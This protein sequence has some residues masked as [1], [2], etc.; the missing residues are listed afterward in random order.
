MSSESTLIASFYVIVQLVRPKC[1]RS[2]KFFC[3]LLATRQ[4]TQNHLLA[5]VG[6]FRSA[7]DRRES[8]RIISFSRGGFYLVCLPMFVIPP[9]LE[10]VTKRLQ[11]SSIWHCVFSE[12]G[13]PSSLSWRLGLAYELQSHSHNFLDSFSFTSII[14]P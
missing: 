13:L 14:T 5:R 10:T 4:R 12:A 6:G 8:C 7:E 9:L 2:E 11:L 3:D 1:R